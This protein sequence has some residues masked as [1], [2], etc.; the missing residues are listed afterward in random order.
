MVKILIAF[1]LVAG[2][3]LYLL[4]RAGG[5]VAIAGEQHSIESHAPA[6][7]AQK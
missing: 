6:A 3:A 5:D 1:V 4:T 7:S 2:G